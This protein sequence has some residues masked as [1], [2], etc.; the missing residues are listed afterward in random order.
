MLDDARCRCE[1]RELAERTDES[2]ERVQ[3]DL[4]RADMRGIKQTRCERK[5]KRNGTKKSDPNDTNTVLYSTAKQSSDAQLGA[6]SIAQLH[7]LHLAADP[8]DTDAS[9]RA[10]EAYVRARPESEG[11]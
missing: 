3:R 2:G 1:R 8:D 11:R 10:R 5:R 7:I 4:A 6:C 9:S